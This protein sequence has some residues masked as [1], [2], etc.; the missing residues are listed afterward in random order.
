MNYF[1]NSFFYA[2]L[3]A[4]SAAFA[5]ESLRDSIIVG[6]IRADTRN[7]LL[8]PSHHRGEHILLL[9]EHETFRVKMW[10]IKFCDR[11]AARDVIL[12]FSVVVCSAIRSLRLNGLPPFLLLGW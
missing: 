4:F 5:C 6:G 12:T 10:F 1:S 3:P 9:G 8:R 11:R 7:E 2:S